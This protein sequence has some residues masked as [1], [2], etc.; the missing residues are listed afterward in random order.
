MFMA[1]FVGLSGYYPVLE[2][3]DD[4]KM[5]LFTSYKETYDYMRQYV[6][7]DEFQIIELKWVKK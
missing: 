2:E 6:E 5:K 7:D 3:G 1:F 4:N